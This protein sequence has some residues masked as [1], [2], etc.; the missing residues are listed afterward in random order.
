[1]SDALSGLAVGSLLAAF[2]CAC[3]AFILQLTR[4]RSYLSTRG[5]GTTSVYV[6]PFCLLPNVL[7]IR[8]IRREEGAI[9]PAI[10]FYVLCS[11]LVLVFFLLFAVS[12]VLSGVTLAKS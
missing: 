11:S 9:P 2:V 8:S 3:L 1:M 5:R 6:F 4:V 10:K 12:G 7:A